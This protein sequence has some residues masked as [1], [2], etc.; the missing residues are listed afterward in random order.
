M[1]LPNPPATIADRGVLDYL[2]LLV[3]TLTPVVSEDRNAPK[4][5]VLLASPNGSV[6]SVTVTDAG[7]LQTTLEFDNSP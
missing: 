7:A 3:K 1:K 6:Y 2:Q 5:S 4:Q